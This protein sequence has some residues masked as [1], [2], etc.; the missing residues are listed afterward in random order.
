MKG[1]HTNEVPFE[2]KEGSQPKKSD[3]KPLAY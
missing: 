2:I 3:T 1:E